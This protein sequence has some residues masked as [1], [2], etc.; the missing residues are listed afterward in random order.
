[1]T[2]SHCLS[3]SVA[4]FLEE[5]LVRDFVKSDVEIHVV[6]T[7]L[8]TLTYSQLLPPKDFSRF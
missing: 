2:W 4:Y 6:Y 7:A 5:F 1:M 3:L 8:I